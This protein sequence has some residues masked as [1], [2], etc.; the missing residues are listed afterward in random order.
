M[1][2]AIIPVAGAAVIP[3]AGPSDRPEPLGSPLDALCCSSGTGDRRLRLPG[4]GSADSVPF[5]SVTLALA[6]ESDPDANFDPDEQRE[7]ILTNANLGGDENAFIH[8][9]VTSMKNEVDATF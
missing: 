7:H 5:G 3:A 2:A 4:G 6:E 9:F 8:G 1:T